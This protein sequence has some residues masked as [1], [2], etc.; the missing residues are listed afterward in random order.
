MKKILFLGIFSISTLSAIEYSTLVEPYQKYEQKADISGKVLFSDF[1]QEKSINNHNRT[2]ILIDDIQ[3]KINL[4][5]LLE[6]EKLLQKSIILE[7]S[8]LTS[9]RNSH[10]KSMLEKNK[11]ELNFISMKQNLND[12]S[13]NIL[14]IRDIISRKNIVI[15]KNM[16][17][18]KIF[19]RKNSF[20]NMNTVLFDYYDI[21]KQKIILFVITEDYKNISKKEIFI[22]GK[23]NTNFKINK[24]SLI[25]DDNNLGTYEIEL[26]SDIQE[27][28][29]GDVVKVEFK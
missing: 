15:P 24:K 29:F 11:E 18:D 6:K 23:L 4:N 26:T 5:S 12:V 14:D 27:F 9:I 17:L 7:K 1:T 3:N 8:I 20:V 19:I 10:N 16:Y 21:S 22:N 2:I 25:K 28:G 13:K